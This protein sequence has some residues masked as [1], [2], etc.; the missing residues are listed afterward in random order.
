[1]KHIRT[2][3]ARAAGRTPAAI[4]PA[5]AQD[6]LGSLS[7]IASFK[8]FVATVLLGTDTLLGAREGETLVPVK[9]SQ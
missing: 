4:G 7:A 5:E 3:T 1:M 2:M 9:S 8:L 6:I